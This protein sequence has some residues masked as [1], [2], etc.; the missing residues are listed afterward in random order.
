[1][2]LKTENSLIRT[3]KSALGDCLSRALFDILFGLF[4]LLLSRNWLAPAQSSRKSPS[5]QYIG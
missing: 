1:M 4:F 3:R 5:S 2:S